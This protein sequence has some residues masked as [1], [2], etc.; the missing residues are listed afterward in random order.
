[1]SIESMMKQ[2][3]KLAALLNHRA[4]ILTEVGVSVRKAKPLAR[5]GKATEA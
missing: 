4:E 1:M 3:E 5:L 2:A